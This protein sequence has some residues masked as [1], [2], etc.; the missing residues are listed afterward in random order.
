MVSAH[1]AD[2]AT[3]GN[4]HLF[5]R[6]R[7]ALRTHYERVR[8]AGA[9]IVK[10]PEDLPYERSYTARDPTGIHGDIRSEKSYDEG[11]EG[12]RTLR[13]SRHGGRP[14]ENVVAFY[15]K[16]ETYE[17]GIK[18]GEGAVRWTRLSCRAIIPCRHLGNVG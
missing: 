3:Q 14:V 6:C 7:R 9:E 2:A 16:R 13:D 10:P 1:E 8:A 12:T 4:L 18:E 17:Q 11:Q 15:N 5:G